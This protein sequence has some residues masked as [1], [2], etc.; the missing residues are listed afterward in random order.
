M[1]YVTAE[2]CEEIDFFVL[3]ETTTEMSVCVC[4]HGIHANGRYTPRCYWKYYRL[5]TLRLLNWQFSFR[6]ARDHFV[7]ITAKNNFFLRSTPLETAVRKT[8]IRFAS[9]GRTTIMPSSFSRWWFVA[10]N[11]F[12]FIILDEHVVISKF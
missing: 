1:E 2:R 6:N 12:I 10:V 5:Y 9:A 8:F 3:N 11:Q 7:H 4:F